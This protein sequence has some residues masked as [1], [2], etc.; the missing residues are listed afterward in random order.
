MIGLH[1][2]WMC[3]DQT[4]ARDLTAGIRTNA[5]I[6][7][8]RVNELLTVAKAYGVKFEVSP[9][10]GSIVESGWRPP[11]VNAG[12]AN[13]APKSKHMFG[14]AVDIY[15]PDG[16]LD[17]WLMSDEA[18]PHLNKIDLWFEHPGST[19]GWSH[20]QC[21]AFGSYRPGGKRWFYP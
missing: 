12:I 4:H 21:V 2:Y 1:D 19:K 18:Q 3:R 8:P 17:E 10:T 14:L 6:L 11:S 7:L 16:D 9:R 15:D 20:L 5:G 13:A